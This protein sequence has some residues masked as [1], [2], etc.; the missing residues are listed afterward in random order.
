MAELQQAEF[1]PLSPGFSATGEALAR[2]SDPDTSHLAALAVEGE[3]ANKLENIVL[4][5]LR[6]HP[7]GL[8]NHELVA[9]T[10]I[11]WN[12]ITPRVHPLVRK[13]FVVD[14]GLRKMGPKGKRVIVWKLR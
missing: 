13:R 8:T 12:T 6:D 10:G 2:N 9:V 4:Q 7:D 11:T 1:G 14:S 3:R 5:A